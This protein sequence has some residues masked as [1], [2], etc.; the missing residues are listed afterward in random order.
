[1]I[2]K[3]KIISMGV[4]R[5]NDE[6]LKK[7]LSFGIYLNEYEKIFIYKGNILSK[8]IYMNGK[9]RHS[10]NKVSKYLNSILDLFRF[11]ANHWKILLN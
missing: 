1:M 8:S 9:K 2:E 4:N 6:K 11:K 3:N 7:E 10:R 5:D